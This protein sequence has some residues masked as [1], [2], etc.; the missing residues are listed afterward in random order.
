MDYQT[1]EKPELIKELDERSKDGKKLGLFRCR[2]GNCDGNEFITQIRLVISGNSKSCGCSRI[3]SCAKHGMK[4]TAEYSIWCSMKDRC[5]NPNNKTYKDYGGR[6][7]YI[8]E[9]W[10]NSFEIFYQDMGPKP[11]PSSSI[12]RKDDS[13][14]YCKESCIWA[15]K[16]QQGREKRNNRIL[17]WKGEKKTLAEW[18]EIT[19]ISRMLIHGRIDR[20][21]WTTDEALSTPTRKDKRQLNK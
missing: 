6:G 3:T 1:M 16:K 4:H 21:G 20:L 17:E 7:V 13:L 14:C 18:S 2:Y 9:E 11:T 15:S 5:Y 12:H 10:K 8:C 19:G